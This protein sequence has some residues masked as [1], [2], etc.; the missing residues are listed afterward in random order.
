M[1]D[2]KINEQKKHSNSPPAKKVKTVKKEKGDGIKTL[3]GQIGRVWRLSLPA[4]LTQITT[5]VMQYIDSA[6]VGSLGENAS[7]SIGL[8]SSTTW[9]FGGIIYAVSAGFSVQVAH[10]IGAK[11]ERAARGVLRHGMVT[12]LVLSSL[13]CICGALLSRPL[14]NLLGGNEAIRSDASKYFL[15]FALMVPF[16]Q[17]NSLSSSFLQCSGDM[18]TP[19]V[20]NALMCGLDVVFNAIFIPKYGV[21]GA[22]IGTAVAAA[23]ISL[24][25]LWRCLFC[26]KSL[27][28]RPGDGTRFDV[29]VLKTAF[30]IGL[31]LGIQEIAMNGAMVVS[32]VIIA[33]LGPT[34]IAA[35]SF[36]VTAESLCY[37]PGYGIA[38][39]A[40]TLVGQSVGAGD[41][42]T[43]KRYGGICT[44]MGAIFMGV[45]GVLM[46]VFCPYVFG[47]LTPVEA[48][49]TLA[50]QVLR[51]GLLAEAFFGI[52]I[53]AAGVLRGAGDT[54]VPGILNLASI[55][56]VRI[57]SALFLVKRLGLH[58]M[59][60]AMAAEL[61]VRGILMLIRQV[62]SKHYALY[63][64]GK[65]SLA[66]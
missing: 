34:E 19:S 15:T 9:L 18:V 14:P 25:M 38:S 51:I 16:S 49:R 23:V 62:T 21:L 64:D 48:V 22:G 32:T 6:M 43:A 24:V 55:W 30:R 44:A 4:I 7:A 37:M 50:A 63:E 59:W 41:V 56:I 27:R 11:N 2:R 61:C 54:L 45:F 17:M 12:G 35:N 8:V 26:N 40:T 39:A 28:L 5:I 66:K 3:S 31:P 65:N 10:C 33:P 52:S 36:A 46:M 60:I 58:G 42:A 57:G 1:K 20:L 47:I 29:T 13:L 53:V